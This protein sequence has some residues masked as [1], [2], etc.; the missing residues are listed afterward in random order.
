M[1]WQ[2]RHRC[3]LKFSGPRAVTIASGVYAPQL[4]LARPLALEVPPV[5]IDAL[6]HNRQDAGSAHR[7][8]RD[9]VMRAAAPRI[10]ALAA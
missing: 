1:L 2:A 9:A 5:H 4:L 7:W 8:L 3:G 10:G 6:W